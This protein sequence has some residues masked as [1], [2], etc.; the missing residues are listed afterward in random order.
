[1]IGCTIILVITAVIIVIDKEIDR[2][3][4]ERIS[5]PLPPPIDATEGKNNEE[6]TGKNW[7]DGGK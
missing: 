6:Q 1:M 7:M 5:T 3:Q 2:N 4:Y